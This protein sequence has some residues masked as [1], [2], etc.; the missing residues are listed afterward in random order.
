MGRRRSNS[1]SSSSGNSS[2]PR[3]PS[4]T[5]TKSIP[6]NQKEPAF[7]ISIEG[8]SKDITVSH[9]VEMFSEFGMVSRAFFPHPEKKYANNRTAIVEYKDE[10]AME[11]ACLRADYGQINGA[12]VRVSKVVKKE[13][14]DKKKKHPLAPQNQN[15]NKFEAVQKRNED[16][17]SKRNLLNGKASKGEAEKQKAQQTTKPVL[18]KK[19][20][21]ETDKKTAA[22][23]TKLK[24]RS[25]SR[26]KQ[27]RRES[28][29]SDSDSSGSSESS[30]ESS[31]SDS[32]HNTRTKRKS[33]QRKQ[34]KRKSTESSSSSDS[35]SSSSS[36]ESRKP[37]KKP[38]KKAEPPKAAF[39]RNRVAKSD[40]KPQKPKQ[41]EPKIRDRSREKEKKPAEKPRETPKDKNP[42]SKPRHANDSQDRKRDTKPKEDATEDKRRKYKRRSS[43]SES[44]NSSSLSSS[45]S[46]ASS[47]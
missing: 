9:L 8:L 35:S 32:V 33:S 31:S 26:S 15:K 29:G 1:S 47:N 13:D 19:P 39:Q 12:E 38:A 11:D 7:K 44:S 34:Q 46:P 21:R 22:P 24:K 16:L 27:R 28:S 10:A 37:S 42:A 14:K 20:S 18:N 45:S 41:E 4:R 2:R 36:E 25:R 43:S 5:S 30:S 17:L 40:P 23:N 6:D 3:S